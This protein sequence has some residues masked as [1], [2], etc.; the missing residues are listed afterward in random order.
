MEL[1]VINT[2]SDGNSYVLQ[3]SNY[4]MLIIECGVNIKKIIEGINFNVNNVSGCLVTHEHS[5]HSKEIKKVLSYGINIYT[6]KGTHK[7]CKTENHYRAKIIQSGKIE[8]IGSFK[9]LPFDI[10]HDANEPVGFVI[11][12][13]ECGN[14]LFLT[15]TVYSPYKFANLNNIIIEV[16]FSQEIIDKKLTVDEDKLFLRNR[17]IQ[18]HFSLENALKLFEVNDISNVNNIVLIH[19]SDTNSNAKQFKETITKATGKNVVIAENNMNIDFNLTP[20]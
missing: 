9:V 13:E 12:H 19:L 17:I 20:F 4:E 7:A 11:K 18:S 6:T 3:S 2:G 8:T 1:K 10:K 5:D 16:N 14:V 15:D